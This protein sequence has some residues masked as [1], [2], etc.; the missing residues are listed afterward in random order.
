MTALYAAI[1]DQIGATQPDALMMFGLETVHDLEH[2]LT[3]T[4]QVREEFRKNLPFPLVLWVTDEVHG[5]LVRS[6][7]DFESWATTTEFAIATPDLL[8]SL[9]QAADNLFTTLLSPDTALS[10]R[11]IV[12]RLELTMLRQQELEAAL[13]DL[14]SREQALE[15]DLQASLCFFCGVNGGVSREAVE[16]LQN[17]LELWQQ[18][19]AHAPNSDTALATQLKLGLSCFFL[20]QC[21]YYLDGQNQPRSPRQVSE[22]PPQPPKSGGSL[23]RSPSILGG[24]G[25]SAIQAETPQISSDLLD[26]KR[27][28]QQAVAIF[29]Q[30]NRPDLVA[31]C[32]GQLKRTLERL[33]DWDQLAAVAQQSLTLHQTYGDSSRLAQ[34]YR[35][36]AE[37]A[38]Q[39]QQGAEA[40]HLAQQALD[41]LATDPE[42]QRWQGLY[43]LTLAKAERL[44]G[45]QEEAI[46]QLKTAYDLGDQGVPRL[47]VQ[48]LAELRDIYLTQKQYLAAFQLKLTRL[49]VEQQYGIRAFVGAGRLRPKREDA[50]K[51]IEPRY[52]IP[53]PDEIAPE[54]RSSGRQLDLDQLLQRR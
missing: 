32:V 43:L 6:A 48:V 19:T 44:L 24:G 3:L 54:I 1:R 15:P 52:P 2:L 45:N 5:R 29:E 20:G 37:A 28:L 38:L 33:A 53:T 16:Q 17:S 7:P 4:N 10:F 35:Y 14:H 36:L 34:D 50:E 13:R 39:R 22:P 26:A 27:Q 18:V 30:A 41:Q 42:N 8:N 46:A 25:A 31:K 40:K 12:A 47:F 51:L 49:S 21:Q 9:H 11:K 23:D